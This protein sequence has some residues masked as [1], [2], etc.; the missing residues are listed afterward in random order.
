M[1]TCYIGKVRYKVN[2]RIL[3]TNYSNHSVNR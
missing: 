1:Y 2:T 3:N